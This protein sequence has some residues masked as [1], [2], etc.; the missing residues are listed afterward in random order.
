M[1]ILT[2]MTTAERRRRTTQRMQRQRRRLGSY[3]STLS[4]A[5]SISPETI[6]SFTPPSQQGTEAISHNLAIRTAIDCRYIH[7]KLQLPLYTICNRRLFTFFLFSFSCLQRG[8][9]YFVHRQQVPRHQLHAAGISSPAASKPEFQFQFQFQARKSI[10]SESIHY[11]IPNCIQFS[12]CIHIFADSILIVIL[13]SPL[14]LCSKLAIP[15][16]IQTFVS[17]L[18]AVSNQPPFKVL[19]HRVDP[20]FDKSIQCFSIQPNLYQ[21][22]ATMLLKVL[23]STYLA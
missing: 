1:T 21:I 7:F 8:P 12:S 22:L 4:A 11:S 10:K 9:L 3:K 20:V 19:L 16:S 5:A 6:I 2:Q 14:T 23:V 17:K 18:V 13:S 15:L